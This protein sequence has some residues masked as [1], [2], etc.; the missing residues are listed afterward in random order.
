MSKV[1][2]ITGASSGIG[3][4]TAEYLASRGHRV[5]GTFRKLPTEAISFSALQMDV[6]DPVSIRRAVDEVLQKEGNRIDVLINNAGLGIMAALEEVSLEMVQQLFST[7][8]Y[9]VLQ[10][11][12]AVL[13]TM[14]VQKSGH[15]I[16][17]SS[18]AGTMGLPFRGM[19]S[20]SKAAVEMMTEALSLEMRPFG[21]KVCSLLPGDVR[22]NISQNRLTNLSSDTSPY[23][24]IISEMNQKVNEDVGKS[25]DPLEISRKIEQ[26]MASDSPKMHYVVAEP[27]Q[28]LSIWLKRLM[29]DRSYEKILANHYGLK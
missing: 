6:T 17:I 4:S 12:Q 27:L 13:P 10:V 14:R 8:V 18:I 21:V 19:Y 16:N 7:N 24:A 26:I 22:T 20:A 28:R 15:I 5:Y 11:T 9:G 2:L 29:P 23:H 25:L 1:I 3:R